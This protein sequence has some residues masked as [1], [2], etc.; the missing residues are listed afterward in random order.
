MS[1]EVF[2]VSVILPTL[3]EADNLRVIVP[4]LLEEVRRAT[5]RFEIIVVDDGS[6]DGT[7]A[8][9]ESGLFPSRYVR[10]IQRRGLTRSLPAALQQGLNA[11]MFPWVCWLDAD[12]SMPADDV[13]RLVLHCRSEAPRA[14]VV[15]SRFIA[16]G[17]FKGLSEDGKR[18]PIRAARNIWNS[19][20][21][22]SAVLLS[23]GLNAVLW[24]SCKRCC[25]DLTSG[26]VI[27]PTQLARKIGMSGGYGDY[28]VRF[29]FLAHLMNVEVIE[30][31]YICQ[32]RLYGET[33]TGSNL[34]QLLRRGL[35]YLAVPGRCRR[36][37][38]SLGE[39]LVDL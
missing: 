2:G 11:A 34:L 33:K 22:I 36:E 5:D 31:P 29:I 8:L 23:R 14:V 16:G 15:G 37:S 21:K 38:R 1:D 19:Q 17:G 32:T 7:D 35:P 27:A 3:N 20:D 24:L 4:A 12:G 6:N 10:F 9:F 30:I 18:N 28:C 13:A 39:R 26:F 25:R